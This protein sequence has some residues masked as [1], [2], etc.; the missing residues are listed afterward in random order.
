MDYNKKANDFAKKH[1]ITL[2]VVGQ[3]EYKKYFTTDTEKRYVFKMKLKRNGKSY[4]FN[5]G[6]SINGG[7]NEPTMYDILACIEKNGY[8]SF[9]DFCSELG[10][11]SDSKS[12]EKIF[13]SVEKEHA[14]VQ[15][16]FGDIL[17]ELL[18]IQ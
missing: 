11:D 6:Q 4:T 7:S 12:A 14:A 2:S 9:E 17:E 1:G 10:Y 5:F 13:K 15:N 18:E 3:P 16:L 8:A